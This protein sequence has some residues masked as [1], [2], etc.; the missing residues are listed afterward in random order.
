MKISIIMYRHI[1][2]C[3]FIMRHAWNSWKVFFRF[4]I[5]VLHFEI[6]IKL[7]LNFM[8]RHNYCLGDIALPHCINQI[9]LYTLK[10]LISNGMH[11]PVSQDFK[12]GLI[13]ISF[14]NQLSLES[15]LTW[16]NK[17]CEKQACR[18]SVGLNQL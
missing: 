13:K 15:T 16:V 1:Q 17:I 14:R 18:N 9:T 7:F 8:R 12:W 2:I 10:V 11:W 6:F 4:I 5:P 3:W